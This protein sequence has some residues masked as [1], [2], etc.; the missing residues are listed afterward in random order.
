MKFEKK[1]HVDYLKSKHSTFDSNIIDGEQ[2]DN[3]PDDKKNT[4]IVI[5]TFGSYKR[6]DNFLQGVISMVE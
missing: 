2:G 6:G 3:F 4:R 5:L 1:R